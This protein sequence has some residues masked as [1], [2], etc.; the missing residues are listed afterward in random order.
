MRSYV[1]VSKELCELC[2]KKGKKKPCVD[3][4]ETKVRD[5]KLCND[6]YTKNYGL[7]NT[8]KEAVEGKK[9]RPQEA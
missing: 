4:F 7:L 2:L 3:I 5:F 9:E 8:Y 1:T 6:C